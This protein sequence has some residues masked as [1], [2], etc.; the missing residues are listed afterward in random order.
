MTPVADRD[1]TEDAVDALSWPDTSRPIIS[2]NYPTQAPRPSRHV[3]RDVHVGRDAAAGGLPPRW[4][5][6]LAGVALLAVLVAVL[7]IWLL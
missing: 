4:P 1:E 7:L 3:G 5:V 2:N 6:I